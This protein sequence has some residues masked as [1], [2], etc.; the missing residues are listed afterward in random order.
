MRH[1]LPTGSE[2]APPAKAP[3]PK[4][5][6]QRAESA[7]A[8]AWRELAPGAAD[9]RRVSQ[10]GDPAELQADRVVVFYL[11]AIR[12]GQPPHDSHGR[13]ISNVPGARVP[14]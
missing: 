12:S 14:A 7:P 11:W 9:K 4:S 1:L 2:H 8:G 3:A 10:P 6:A 5:A 13:L